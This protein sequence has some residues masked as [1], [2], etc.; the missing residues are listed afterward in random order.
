MAA[1]ITDDFRRS[2]T[3]FLLNDIKD[4][5]TGAQD[6]P[7]SGTYEYFIGIGK[8][9]A[10]ENDAGDLSET[11]QNFSTPLPTG[12][13]IE[14]KE[15]IDNLIGAVAIKPANAYHVIPRIDWA[16]NRRFKRWN[17]NDPTMFDV[18]TDGAN[19]YYPCYAIYADKIY[20]CLDNDSNNSYSTNGSYIPGLSSNTPVG[21]A[22]DRLPERLDDNY[23]WAYVADLD[24]NS[25]FNTD[26]FVSISEIADGSATD[27]TTAT[28]GMVYGFEIINHGTG[29]S[30]T[31]FKLLLNDNDGAVSTEI[32]LTVNNSGVG[33]SAK[34]VI[35]T[36][37]S[38]PLDFQAQTNGTVRASVVPGPGITATT[39]PVIRPLVAPILG[40]GYT[41]TADLPSFYAGLA[42]NYN[43]DVGGELSTNVS[44]RQI[45]LLR[46]PT[47]FDDDSPS[48]TGDGLYDNEEV[49]N[50]LRRFEFG[51]LE[52]LSNIS[53]GNIITETTTGLTETP[54]KA[55]VDFVDDTNKYVY[56]H[57]NE[58]AEINQQEFSAT[59]DITIGV[60][61]YTGYTITDPE[62]TPYSGE[63]YFVENRK[64]IQRAASQE[65]EI[66]LVI[67]F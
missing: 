14:A 10:W 60:T 31:D 65:E 4:Q 27:A 11:D 36:S 53:A 28:G 17:E 46:N 51:A 54:A 41:P 44:Y 56:F 64:P 18:T 1:I 16:A 62:Y 25:E 33:S 9:D 35:M 67:Q 22:S 58:S 43:G 55:Y 48:P 20:V 2:S 12:S 32:D 15:V 57:Q 3:T 45:S 59:G 5:N 40:F 61:S 29:I 13:V 21:E 24:N 26:Q 49:Y 8:S 42:V 47:R 34:G 52:D 23:I 63:V 50:T 66:K 19:T 37:Y 7:N 38:A 6:S 39:L 30:G